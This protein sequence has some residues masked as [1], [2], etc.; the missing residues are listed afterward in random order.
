MHVAK[1]VQCLARLG[2]MLQVQ[3]GIHIACND[4]RPSKRANHLVPLLGNYLSEPDQQTSAVDATLSAHLLKL[5]ELGTISAH[6]P[7][8]AR[9]A[10]EALPCS[11]RAALNPRISAHKRKVL[12]VVHFSKQFQPQ[13][14]EW[15]WKHG[16]PEQFLSHSLAHEG[17][18]VVYK[19]RTGMPADL[20]HRPAK[21][22][23]GG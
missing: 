9:I 3:A 17:A 8:R 18:G 4:S 14:A 5:L 13:I 16:S 20:G 12:N 21:L 15:V 7:F 22:I 2:L 6:L 10:C 1:A 23:I 19:H 11:L